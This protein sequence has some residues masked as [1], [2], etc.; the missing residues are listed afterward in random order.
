[1]S[2]VLKSFDSIPQLRRP[3]EFEL[4]GGLAHPLFQLADE[5]CRCSGVMSAVSSSASSGTVT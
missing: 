2:R 5:L 3:F 4:L 1:M